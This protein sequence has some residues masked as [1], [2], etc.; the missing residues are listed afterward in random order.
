MILYDYVLSADCYAARL[1][2]ALTGQKLEA[3]AVDFYPGAAEKSAAFRAINPA[4]T[5]PVL[6]DGPLVLTELPAILTH[7]AEGT[8]FA[9]DGATAQEWLA[10]S[11]HFA[12]SLGGARL[13]DM[14]EA[15]GDIDAL[16]AEGTIWLRILEAALFEAGEAGHGFLLGE[17]PSIADIAVFPHVALA[18]DGGLELGAYPGIRLWMRRLR[19]LPGFIEMPGIH[20]LH[21]L[22]PEPGSE[23]GGAAA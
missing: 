2:A 4:G 21:D 18:P 11:R 7:L 12:T 8:A 14:L 17:T 9:A 6:V 23:Y 16:R 22:K 5:L 10:R 20:R 3:K 13:H 19:A 1:L 15:P